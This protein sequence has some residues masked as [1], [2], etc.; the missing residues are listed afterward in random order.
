MTFQ[1]RAS[2]PLHGV[3]QQLPATNQV[4]AQGGLGQGNF[5]SPPL[6]PPLEPTQPIGVPATLTGAP[7]SY[8]F[9]RGP[10]TSRIMP[11][12][13]LL[14]PRRAAAADAVAKSAGAFNELLSE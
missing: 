1:P 4:V 8:R 3:Q 14:T 11:R 5:L 12:L 13:P 9:D 2:S 7:A 10:Q 6:Y